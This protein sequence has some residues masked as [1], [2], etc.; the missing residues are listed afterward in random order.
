MRKAFV[1]YV[2]HQIALSNLSI[3]IFCVTLRCASR[4]GRKNEECEEGPDGYTRRQHAYDDE[5]QA[6]RRRDHRG[7]DGRRHDRQGGT[8]THIQR[9]H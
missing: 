1:A 7:E 2:Y 8:G 5:L 9:R 4:S 6:R 3:N